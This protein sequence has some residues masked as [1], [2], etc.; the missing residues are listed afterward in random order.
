VIAEGTFNEQTFTQNIQTKTGITLTNADYKGY[1]LYSISA[2][3]D[4]N[5]D[6][7]F[8]SGST[9][10]FGSDLAVK[11]C[12]DVKKGDSKP[13][14]GGVLD[15]FS[16]LGSSS[17]RTASSVPANTEQNLENQI[18]AGSAISSV[19]L[20]KLDLLGF[21]INKGA[22]DVSISLQLHFPDNAS[23]QDAR[24]TISGA[25]SVLK[26][27]TV[28]TDLKTLLGQIQYNVS[29]V[30]LNMSSKTSMQ[31]LQGIYNSINTK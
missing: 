29:D 16:K 15:T 10:V 25:V 20:P 1:K 13:I 12:I 4:E 31:N 11:D 8:F 23:A 26:G 27:T 19:K 7:V 6:M 2:G 3:T 30:W 21:S 5:L 14:S 9:M 24:D 17:M 22:Q 18:P 28:N